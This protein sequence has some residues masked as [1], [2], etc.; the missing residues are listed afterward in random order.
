MILTPP[1]QH[2]FDA[3]DYLKDHNPAGL[4]MCLGSG[5]SLVALMY[6]DHIK[7]QRI[8][9]TSDK[10][11]IL[12]TWAEQIY[13]HTNY[14]CWI[15]PSEKQMQG[16]STHT[17]DRPLCVLVNYDLLPSRK[18]DFMKRYD[19]WIGD[20]SSEFKDQR[21]HKHKAMDA[22]ASL[23][24]Q[25][26]ILNGK[27][28]T[29]RLEDVYGQIK[30]IDDKEKIAR[31][32]TH[33]R[34]RYMQQDTSGYG[35]IPKR[36]AFTKLREDMK[37]MS[38]WLDDGS[39]IGLPEKQEYVVS[40]PMTEDQQRLDREF[41]EDFEGN[42]KGEKVETKYAAVNFI[43]RIQVAG[44]VF[45]K[46]DGWD[47]VPNN[48]LDV[49]V[50]LIKDNPEDKI[51]CWHTYIPETELISERLKKEGISYVVVDRPECS[52]ELEMFQEP[53]VQVCLIRTSLCRGLNK[54]V[55]ADIGVYFSYPL[56]YARFAQS[57]GRTCRLTS[58]NDS[59]VYVY[60][61]IDNGADT[62]VYNMLDNKRS[63][64]MTLA[65][66]REINNMD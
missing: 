3:L 46:E 66:L 59:S 41:K 11:N 25:K 39:K 45:R 56:S 6:A 43:K 8:L 34:R 19:L 15:R 52:F 10:N 22:I 44:G 50:K 31:A 40:V 16:F 64:S 55:G 12:N 13:Q 53:N 58:K 38:Y 30:L 18:F 20:E 26:L 37:D 61:I 24:P 51:V 63:M 54:L 17:S 7:A 65:N 5:K 1:K 48:K 29:E 62:I 35:W 21:T 23:I 57:Q 36:S 27:L 2:Q 9:I 60:L 42:F 49:L 47:E 28:M 14:D 4:F 32:L 33:F